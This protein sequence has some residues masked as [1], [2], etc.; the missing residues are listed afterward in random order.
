MKTYILIGAGGTGTQFIG[1]G[2]AY[3]ENYH[4]HRGEEW[5]MV[6]IDGDHY[7]TKNLERQLAQ[8]EHVGMNKA[9]AMAAMYNR[10]PIIAVPHFIGKEDLETMFEDGDTV[11]LGVDN[12]SV[13]ALVEDRALA[14]Q[15]A[16]VFN[17]GNEVHDGS[18]QLF[19]RENGENKTP[20]LSKYHREIQFI[21][22]DD[23]AAMTCAQAAALPGG[24]Q[25]II[26]N[27][28]A[29]HHMLTALWRYHTGEWMTGWTEL[30]FDLKAG[31][32]EHIDQRIRKNWAD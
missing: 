14:L 24:E 22:A 32:V 19:V 12:Y 4:G 30:Q 8:P 18:V 9:A 21:A 13:R 7:E 28:A 2:L 16:V 27:M 11:F 26:A 5:Q 1:S 31:T 15:N 25:L 10:Y 23:R 3:L 6:V 17:A 20:R 29:A